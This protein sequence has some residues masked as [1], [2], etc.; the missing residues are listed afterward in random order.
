[1]NYLIQNSILTQRFSEDLGSSRLMTADLCNSLGCLPSCSITGGTI[2]V[3]HIYI[4][5]PLNISVV[6]YNIGVIYDLLKT[7]KSNRHSHPRHWKTPIS[8]NISIMCQDNKTTQKVSYHN[9]WSFFLTPIAQART[10]SSSSLMF[11]H[12]SLRGTE[13]VTSSGW[14]F[15]IHCSKNVVKL[16]N[17]LPEVHNILRFLQHISNDLY[18]F[19]IQVVFSKP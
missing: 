10:R 19:H 12:P 16:T 15:V 11:V 18:C 8:S 1:M 13:R 7:L 6:Y 5:K 9:S 2:K 4:K 3:F 14:F 17:T